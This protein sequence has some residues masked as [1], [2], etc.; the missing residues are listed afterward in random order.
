MV[1]K[2]ELIGTT[3][4]LTLQTR[5]RIKRYRYNRVRVHMY[6][7]RCLT[8]KGRTENGDK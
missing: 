8:G 4:Y 1:N 6:V 5:Y 3:E 2:G 7:K